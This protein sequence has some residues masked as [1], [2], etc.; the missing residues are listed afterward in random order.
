[1]N[2][3]CK[4]PAGS[5]WSVDPRVLLIRHILV[6]YL[7]PRPVKVSVKRK[8]TEIHNEQLRQTG[9]RG[10]WTSLKM[11]VRFVLMNCQLIKTSTSGDSRELLTGAFGC[12]KMFFSCLFFWLV[13][14][15]K[16][17]RRD[18]LYV[19]S[20]LFFAILTPYLLFDCSKSQFIIKVTCDRNYYWT[21]AVAAILS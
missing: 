10:S 7:C 20:V 13:V 18:I 5:H 6:Q 9:N 17:L 19:H 8:S 3:A 15:S 16:N 2:V 21:A 12:W 11:V 14:N 1:M 4:W